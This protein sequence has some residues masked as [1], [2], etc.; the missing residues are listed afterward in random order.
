[1]I[2]RKGVF[3]FVEKALPE[4]IK[5]RKDVAYL[6][7]GSGPDQDAIA[8]TIEKHGLKNYVFLLGRTSDETLSNLY[9]VADA[10][11]MPNIRVKGDLEGFGLVAL[12]AASCGTPVVASNIEG[13][14][15]AIMDGKNG[16]L[17]KD[18]DTH[19]YVQT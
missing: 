18:K 11:I 8:Q 6:V 10:F 9:N 13:I 17:V 19:A 1:L 12:E 15:D 14:K 2:A 7:S 3:W 5:K 16:F 4:I